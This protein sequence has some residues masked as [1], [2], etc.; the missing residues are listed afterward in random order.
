MKTSNWVKMNEYLGGTAFCISGILVFLAFFTLSLTTNAVDSAEPPTWLPYGAIVTCLMVEIGLLFVR[1]ASQ[2]Q[3]ANMEYGEQST[4]SWVNISKTIAA[5]GQ[6]ISF[7][8]GVVVLLL[9]S[10]VFAVWIEKMLGLLKAGGSG[11]VLS[12][13]SRALIWVL[14]GYA[15]YVVIRSLVGSKVAKGLQS[16]GGSPQAICS[17]D[18]DETINIKLKVTIL[19]KGD[20][21]QPIRI[22]FN[23]LT[24]A[25]TMTYWESEGFL[26]GGAGAN[27]VI[28]AK[29]SIQSQIAYFQGKGR[30]QYLDMRSG[31][32]TVLLLRGK[33]IFYLLSC[34]DEEAKAV[35]VAFK[36][37]QWK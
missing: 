3:S 8:V 6:R 14:L 33:D 21:P 25:R 13:Q 20:K 15:V 18:A 37:Q 10:I 24:E 19:G 29:D 9:V 2:L 27:D 36:K 30:P 31:S 26:K 32:S 5:V 4:N 28:F 22:K 17:V 11:I 34:K 7:V 35:E 23:E 12:S 16:I 1:R